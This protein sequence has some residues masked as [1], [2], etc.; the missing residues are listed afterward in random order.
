VIAFPAN[1]YLSVVDM[2]SPLACVV[3]LRSVWPSPAAAKMLLI[4]LLIALPLC[5][6]NAAPMFWVPDEHRHGNKHGYF[7]VRFDPPPG[8]EKATVAM[9]SDQPITYVIPFFPENT[10]F[11]RLQGSLLYWNPDFKKLTFGSPP[12]A[13]RAVFGNAMG[14]AI[15]RQLDAAGDNLFLLRLRGAPSGQDILVMQY[16]G[17]QDAGKPCTPI[18]S[19]A[20]QQLELCPAKRQP[21]PECHGD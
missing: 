8:I 1:R 2:V 13:R 18:A 9:L 17:V 20:S 19:K 16:F 12:S 11:A 3:A 15:C 4:E 14:A 10:V 7:G 6:Y 5:T 21:N